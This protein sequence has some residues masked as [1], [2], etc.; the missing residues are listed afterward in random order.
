MK[1]TRTEGNILHFME[2]VGTPVTSEGPVHN[3]TLFTLYSTL[4]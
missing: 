4:Q 2:A 1:Q 3:K